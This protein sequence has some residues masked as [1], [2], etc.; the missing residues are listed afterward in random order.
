MYIPE[1]CLQRCDI[2]STLDVFDTP[3]A[4]IFTLMYLILFALGVH[5]GD[6][7]IFETTRLLV[8]SEILHDTGWQ[9]RGQLINDTQGWKFSGT[10]RSSDSGYSTLYMRP[11]QLGKSDCVC[12]RVHA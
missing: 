4:L 11:V 6:L 5:L 1:R 7:I 8:P 2:F 3:A 10:V 9:V 12:V